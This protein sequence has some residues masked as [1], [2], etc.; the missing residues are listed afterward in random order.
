MGPWFHNLHLPDGTQTAPD[1]PLGDFP[2]YNWK[3][4]ALRI[5]RDLSGW[6]VLDVGCNAGYYSFRVARW[7]ADVL[8][9]D[10]DERYLAQARWAAEVYGLED[11][12]AFERKQVYD[13]VQEE[14]Q[15][16]MVLFLGVLYHMR[17]PVLAL[18]IMR[19][20]TRRLMV[21]QTLMTPSQAEDRGVSSLR[22]DQTQR[23]DEQGWP[24]LSFIEGDLAGDPTNW[25][26][27][28]ASAV[29]ALLRSSGFEVVDAQ[30]DPFFVCRPTSDGSS[31]LEWNRSEYLAAVQRPWRGA[32]AGK[33][34]TR[35]GTLERPNA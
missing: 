32:E 13:L 5:P 15:F 27:P 2:R 8:G 7:G 14:E 18:D 12:V 21:F 6:R 9:I 22:F 4:F 31:H 23:L 26:V 17:Y 29:H 35:E 10:L 34:V 16:D 19:E 33:L 11:R 28:N 20:L 3:T 25:W 30:G 1:H 24:R